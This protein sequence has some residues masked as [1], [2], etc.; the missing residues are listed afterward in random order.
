MNR[1]D[2]TLREALRGYS[3]RIAASQSVPPSAA[4]WLRAERRKRRLALERAERPLRI[5][6][7][8]G[9]VCAVIAA[10]WILVQTGSV[11][12]L[13]SFGTA[14]LV[15]ALASLLLVV[16]GCWAMVLASRRSF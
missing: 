8:L 11:R 2:E 15:S 12:P 7:A 13:P 4:V 9:L 6:Q 14:V 10:G 5:M 16:A 3:A 1:S